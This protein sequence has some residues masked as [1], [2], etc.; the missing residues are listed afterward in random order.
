M[1]PFSNEE[2]T[3]R[4]CRQQRYPENK[5]DERSFPNRGEM[6]REVVFEHQEQKKGQ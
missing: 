2:K 3:K 6:V 5:D 4:I 1:K